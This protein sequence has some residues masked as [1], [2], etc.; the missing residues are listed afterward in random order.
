MK[1][2]ILKCD[3]PVGDIVLLTAAVRDLHLSY[4][5]QFHTAVQ[6][7]FPEIWEHNVNITSLDKI[8]KDAELIECNYSLIDQSNV[9]PYHCIHAFIHFFNERLGLDIKPRDFKGNIYISDQE[10]QWCSQVCELTGEDIPFWIIVT[11]GKND[12]TT[13]WW[14]VERYQEVVNHFHNKV[15]FV[16]VGAA[17]HFHPPLNGVVDLRGQT[18]LRQL[19]RLVY[20]AQGVLCP[21]TSLM[22]LAAAVDTKA[23]APKNRPCVVVAGGREPSQWEAYPNHQFI[24]TNGSLLCC[25]QGGCWK[26]RTRPL[27]DG[28]EFDETEHLCLDPVGDTP[29]CMDIISSEQ[30]I[31]RIEMYFQGGAINYITPAQHEAAQKITSQEIVSPIKQEEQKYPSHSTKTERLANSIPRYSIVSDSNSK[32]NV[33]LV[34]VVRNEGP[35][36]EE[37]I[38]Y[39]L[40]LGVEHVYLYDD[41]STDNSLEAYQTMYKTGRL[42]V[43]RALKTGQQH[44]MQEDCNEEWRRHYGHLY[45]FIMPWRVD[46]FLSLKEGITLQEL[47]DAIPEDVGQVRLNWKLFGSNNHLHADFTKFVIERYTKH[48]LP[49]YDRHTKLILRIKAMGPID[50]ESDES[51]PI[52]AHH[53]VILPE[54]RTVGAD[55]TSPVESKGTTITPTIWDGWAICNHYAVKSFEE[56]ITIKKAKPRTHLHYTLLEAGSIIA[57]Q[58]FRHKDRNDLTDESMLSRKGVN[59]SSQ[60]YTTFSR[61]FMNL[62]RREASSLHVL[63]IVFFYSNQIT[64]KLIFRINL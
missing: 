54:Y 53:S 59:G 9:A 8:G 15:Q 41:G 7:H 28:S 55:L 21:V 57:N 56:F 50:F 29:H 49:S 62:R 22:H 51:R 63:P 10:K 44:T 39:H 61:S 38:A 14:P 2:L 26:S 58:Y 33:A 34:A 46:E 3:L 23:E 45:T 32:N 43:H 52:T 35:Y 20:H 18:D 5:G 12:V 42:T 27:G 13:K 37:W 24:H 25:D 17:E 19:V 48:C 36:L 40:M 60:P 6:T 1:D 16:Q 64:N 11:G 31:R 4:P 30:V 47:L